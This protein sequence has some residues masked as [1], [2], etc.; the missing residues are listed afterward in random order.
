LFFLSLFLLIFVFYFQELHLNFGYVLTS[1][2]AKV[3]EDSDD[4]FDGDNI[5]AA[6]VLFFFLQ[7]HI[8]EEGKSIIIKFK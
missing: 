8:N 3:Q 2:R 5:T 6:Q 1:I 4:E 7:L